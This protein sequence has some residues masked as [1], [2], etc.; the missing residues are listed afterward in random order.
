MNNE[1]KNYDAKI[2]NAIGK[3]DREDY[4]IAYSLKNYVDFHKGMNPDA[5]GI[6]SLK[7][8]DEGLK[9]A[10]EIGPFNQ[11]KIG[12]IHGR[13]TPSQ[14]GFGKIFELNE[15]IANNLD[16]ILVKDK[17]VTNELLLEAIDN[18]K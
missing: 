3:V 7:N 12:K 4:E 14:K 8:D 5:F 10:F 2:K 6:I 16:M 13:N 17:D 1:E 11:F 15:T 9:Y 18:L